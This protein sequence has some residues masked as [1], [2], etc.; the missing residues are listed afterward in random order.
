MDDNYKDAVE[1]LFVAEGYKSNDKYDP[2]RLTIW[3]IAEKYHPD[4]VAEIAGLPPDKAKERAIKFYYDE[5]WVPNGCTSLPFPIDWI[6]FEVAVNPGRNWTETY[7]NNCIGCWWR[8]LLFRR[9]KYYCTVKEVLRRRY[10]QGWL[11][12]VVLLWEKL[13]AKKL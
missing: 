11:N 6:T 12:R 13:T 4:V 7:R 2:G 1:H 8:D 10:I 5:Y 3:G 9:L